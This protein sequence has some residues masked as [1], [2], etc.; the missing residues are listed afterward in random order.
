MTKV[1]RT[2][3]K[4][5]PL[6]DPA[7]RALRESDASLIYMLAERGR[8]QGD[9]L[10]RARFALGLLETS[11]YKTDLLDLTFAKL[12]PGVL[13]VVQDAVAAIDALEG[14]HGHPKG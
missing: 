3:S 13:D 2:M 11:Y 8:K 1:P 14:D 10:R 6:H 5:P 4:K 7:Y 12:W 9:A